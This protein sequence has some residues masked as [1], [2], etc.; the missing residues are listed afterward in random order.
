MTGLRTHRPGA[1][2]GRVAVAV[3]AKV[4][5]P[6]QVKTRLCPPLTALQAAALARCFLL[7]RLD[8]L[9]EVPDSETL[10]AFDP[11]EREEEMR[12]LVSPGT[13]LVPQEGADLG[14]RMD[15]LLTGLLAEGHAGAI[16]IGTD[17]PTLPTAY[18]RRACDAIRDAAVDLVI[19]P[20][21]DGGY[22]LIGL[23]APA[24]ALF[25]D[26]AWST[27]TV[28]AETLARAGRLGLRPA[29]LPSWFDVDRGEDL[30]R[31]RAPA[32]REAFRPPRTLAV[33]RDGRGPA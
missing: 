5:E 1:G 12:S 6:G 19:G 33:L 13:R 28:T 15:R 18:L 32:S 24:A 2:P 8:Q 29:L 17:S 31:L 27:A 16:V 14:A 23:R 3:M 25:V 10:V 26:M 22:Y 7:D 4:P 21:E 20:A 9:R 11:K 30:A